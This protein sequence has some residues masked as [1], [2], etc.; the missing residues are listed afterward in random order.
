MPKLKLPKPGA[1]FE[2]GFFAGRFFI[3]DQPHA[4]IVA[5]KA[6]GQMA[7]MRWNDSTAIVTDA[8]SYCNGLANTQ[9]MAKAGSKLAA[10]IL[11][12]RIGGFDDWHLPSRLQLLLA[13]HELA[14][15]K[16]FA[17]GAKEAFDRNWY[18]S[19]TQH[20]ENGNYAWYQYFGNGSQSYGRESNEFRARAV[21]TIK[22]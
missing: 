10:K 20:A 17:E 2:G 22:L 1:R 5:P 18:W 11:A 8:T 16:T 19:S 7:P 9:A 3:G 12:L 13:Y 21:R 6:K 14:A 15:V 4:L